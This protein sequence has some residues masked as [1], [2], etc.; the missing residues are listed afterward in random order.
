MSKT[1]ARFIA[2][3]GRVVTAPLNKVR[4]T[5]CRATAA[6]YLIDKIPVTTP[7]GDL[8]M[9]CN[10]R[11]T[12]MY[13]PVYM[14]HEPDT[15]V[16]IDAMPED[17]VLWDIGANVGI[18][19]MYAGL[20]G[21]QVLAFEPASSTY[22]TLIKNLE[23]NSLLDKVDAYCLAFDDQTR[24]GKLNMAGNISG[25]SMHAFERDSHSWDEL[26]TVKIAHPTMGFS[27]D[28][29]ISLFDPPLPT[30]IKLDVD[31]TEREII[32]GA[33]QLLIDNPP[34]SIW[35]EVDGALERD[36]NQGIIAELDGMGYAPNYKPDRD[37]NLEFLPK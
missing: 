21:R 4:R 6:Q 30:H 8:L 10:S 32:V 3:F 27:I 16:W 19:T 22:F 35:V 14:S 25:S 26:I 23:I 12:A 13:P 17:A 37:R 28:T 31:S 11:E 24:L 36:R 2:N 9:Y 7:H 15:L 20:A 1:V 34:A 29:F 18:Y 33:R 5:S